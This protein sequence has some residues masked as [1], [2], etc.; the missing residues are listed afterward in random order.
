VSVAAPETV[1]LPAGD[2]V[3]EGPKLRVLHVISGLTG[4]GAEGV[5][6]RLCAASPNIDHEV[7]AL[8][9]EGIRSDDL[10]ALGISLIHLNM[11]TFAGMVTSLPRLIRKVRLSRP[12]IIQTWLY[13]GDLVGGLAGFLAGGPP[14]LW[15]VR[16]STNRGDSRQIRALARINARFANWLPHTIISPARRAAAYHVSLGYQAHKFSIVPNGYDIERFAPDPASRTRLRRDWGVREDDFVV[17]LVARDHPQKDHP[18]LLRA[19]ARLRAR[20]L[21]PTCMLAGSGVTPGAPAW[22]P[23]VSELGLSDQLRFLGPQRDVP[24]LMNA[25][26]AHVLSSRSGEAFPNVVAEAM[27]CGTP[28]VVT[29]VG[30]AAELVGPSGVVVPPEDP[31]A[32]ALAIEVLW[33][34]SRDVNAYR[35]RGEAARRRVVENYSLARMAANY[36]H[37]WRVA[38]GRT[39]EP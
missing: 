38:C 31:E 1:T 24:A 26:D 5:L 7:V 22:Y 37:L 25:L 4:G 3:R 15:N 10:R 28:G 39:G 16:H 14:L 6:V 20:G 11:H 18:T 32:L 23:M 33:Q 13:H 9:G 17:G 36:E 21:R 8:T 35:V 27:A 30:D 19:L 12:D 29:D 2:D 34:E